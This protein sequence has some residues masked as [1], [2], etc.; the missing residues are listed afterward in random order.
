MKRTF[1]RRAVL[2]GASVAGLVTLA[3]IPTAAPASPGKLAA[4]YCRLKAAEQ[5]DAVA[6]AAADEVYSEARR[7][8]PPRPAE[9]HPLLGHAEIDVSYPP[10]DCARLHQLLDDWEA[11]CRPVL[12]AYGWPALRE[13]EEAVTE[14]LCAA[15]DAMSAT[16]AE[17]I[18]DMMVK[19]RFLMEILFPYAGRPRPTIAQCYDPAYGDEHEDELSD[20]LVMSLWADAQRLAGAEG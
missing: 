4:V 5:A 13:R 15:W 20:K 6:N 11:A 2:K 10:E 19:L 14:E 12:E 18:A 16:P 17:S 3:A 7:E 1:A 9:L 8:F